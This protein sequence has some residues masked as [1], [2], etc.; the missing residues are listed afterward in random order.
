MAL[1][2]LGLSAALNFVIIFFAA[3]ALV[4]NFE[5]QKQY[6]DTKKRAAICAALL[7]F[8][9]LGGGVMGHLAG[10]S[11]A[12]SGCSLSIFPLFVGALVFKFGYKISFGLGIAVSFLIALIMAAIGL[13]MQF[14]LAA[15]FTVGG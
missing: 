2:T 7:T 4:L 1:A 9:F 15:A 11:G 3:P 14:A 5:P 10:T 12:S 13:A 8:A 6:L